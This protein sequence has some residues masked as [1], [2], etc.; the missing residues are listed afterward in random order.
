MMISLLDLQKG[1]VTSRKG[2]VSRN[3]MRVAYCNSEGVTSR[4]GRVSRN[5]SDVMTATTREQSR[6]ARGV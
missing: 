1:M 5:K 3:E 6:P 4:K 2:R